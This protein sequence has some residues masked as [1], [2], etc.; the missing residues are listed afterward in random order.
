[1]SMMPGDYDARGSQRALVLSFLASTSL[2]SHTGVR[3]AD[4]VLEDRL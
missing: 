1:M 3:E 4:V 2:A